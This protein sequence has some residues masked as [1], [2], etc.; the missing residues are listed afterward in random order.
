MA[1]CAEYADLICLTA[2][3]PPAPRALETRYDILPT[4][5]NFEPQHV[6][7]DPAH[8]ARNSDFFLSQYTPF[9]PG[10]QDAEIFRPLV[11]QLVRDFQD[12]VLFFAARD[13]TDLALLKR[14]VIQELTL[15]FKLPS[16]NAQGDDHEAEI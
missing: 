6:T 8:V 2:S 11:Q 9:D 1:T 13:T 16:Q 3:P 15:A 5:G 14:L 7:A 12:R 4:G 10:I